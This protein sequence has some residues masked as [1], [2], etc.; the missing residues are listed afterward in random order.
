MGVVCRFRCF[1]T[2]SLSRV[3][4]PPSPNAAVV[5][6]KCKKLSVQHEIGVFYA[7]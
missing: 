6:K 5:A 1:R 4:K 2:S 7:N 3:L